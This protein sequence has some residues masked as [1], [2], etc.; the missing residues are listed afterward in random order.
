MITKNEKPGNHADIKDSLRFSIA[1]FIF[2][3]IKKTNKLLL[4][5]KYKTKEDFVYIKAGNLSIKLKYWNKKL[6]LLIGSVKRKKISFISK[7]E[8]YL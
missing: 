7:R 2:V 8:I 3:L 6:L 5:W 1:G 4:Y